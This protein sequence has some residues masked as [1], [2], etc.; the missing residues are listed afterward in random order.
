MPHWLGAESVGS[1]QS[2]QIVTQLPGSKDLGL[3]TTYSGLLYVEYGTGG[4][5][6]RPENFVCPLLF[7]MHRPQ[8]TPTFPPGLLPYQTACLKQLTAADQFK[9]ATATVSVASIWMKDDVGAPDPVASV[10]T[11]SADLWAVDIGLL[12]PASV[13]PFLVCLSVD[14]QGRMSHIYSVSYRVDVLTT[15]GAYA[16]PIM[17]TQTSPNPGNEW[18][19]RIINGGT[20]Q[21]TGQPQLTPII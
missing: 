3:L 16:A 13:N 20:R 21:V 8:P 4:G 17:V 7:I 19:G 18:D 14:V 2:M 12:P 11:A 5:P 9:A 1:P 10:L 6:F 15:I